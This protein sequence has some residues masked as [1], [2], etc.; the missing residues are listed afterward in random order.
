M[1]VGAMLPAPKQ[2]GNTLKAYGKED[3]YSKKRFIRIPNNNKSNTNVHNTVWESADTKNF[4]EGMQIIFV[5]CKKAGYS[6]YNNDLHSSEKC[7]RFKKILD[8]T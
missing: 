1:I 4:R 3:S 6:L 5:P 2:K 7:F 8:A